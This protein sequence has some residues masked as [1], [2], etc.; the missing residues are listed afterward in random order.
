MIS[1]NDK[2]WFVEFLNFVDFQNFLKLFKIL[3]AS[4]LTSNNGVFWFET[5]TLIYKSFSKTAKP[6]LSNCDI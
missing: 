6:D 5:I 1:E 3:N 2:T 4:F